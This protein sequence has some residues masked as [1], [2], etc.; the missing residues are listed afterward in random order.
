MIIKD[1]YKGLSQVRKHTD[2]DDPPLKV[3]GGIAI[4]ELEKIIRNLEQG[5]GPLDL[6]RKEYPVN[7]QAW[8]EAEEVIKGMKRI[9]Q[10]Q[11]PKVQRIKWQVEAAGANSGDSEEVPCISTVA[12][13][14][15][16]SCYS[17]AK[18]D[19]VTF[20]WRVVFQTEK[21]HTCVTILNV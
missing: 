12:V 11:H 9:K 18:Q 15:L 14:V 4:L 19:F 21:L 2:P 5:L 1:L 16:G 13:R 20:V 17:Y 6:V 3:L 7:F 10:L 8:L